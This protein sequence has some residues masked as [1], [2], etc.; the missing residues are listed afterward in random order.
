MFVSTKLDVYKCMYEI[1]KLHVAIFEHHQL[2]LVVPI[3]MYMYI[4][5]NIKISNITSVAF[6]R[7]VEIYFHRRLTQ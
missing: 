2:G 7:P 3:S 6:E 1:F 5:N 4:F